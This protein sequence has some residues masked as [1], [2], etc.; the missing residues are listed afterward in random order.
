MAS[1]EALRHSYDVLAEEYAQRI[2]GE[3]ADKPLDRALLDAFAEMV[4]GRGLVADVGSGPGHVGRY[5]RDRGLDVVGIDLSPGMIDVAR[6]LNPEMAFEVASMLDLPADD[7]AWSGI[8]AFYSIIHVGPQRLAAA[9][10]EFY[11]SLATGGLLLVAF[12]IGG[13][14]IHRDEMWGIE[15]DLDAYHFDRQ[16]VADVVEQARFTVLAQLEREPN[17][18]VEYPSRRAYIL[19]R[20]AGDRE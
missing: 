4:P 14:T 15:V 7:G 12:H 2:V 20:K 17:E 10:A 16:V 18:A 11:R 5:L 8:V 1:D 9:F 6:R 19:A 3:L 13:E